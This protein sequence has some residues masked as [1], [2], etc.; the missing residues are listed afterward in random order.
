[1]NFAPLFRQPH[2]LMQ[3]KL[4]SYERFC[5][6]TRFETEAPGNMYE[7]MTLIVFLPYPDLENIL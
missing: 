6:E 2:I 5:S 1:M 3:T 7:E 4:F